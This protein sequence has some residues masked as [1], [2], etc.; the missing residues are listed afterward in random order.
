MNDQNFKNLILDYPRESL[1]FFAPEEV[2][3]DIDQ[4]NI[5]TLS[6][7]MPNYQMRK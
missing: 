3:P 6:T 1:Q 4:A 2:T 5:L 7:I